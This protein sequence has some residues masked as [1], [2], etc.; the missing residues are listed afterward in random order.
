MVQH[1]TDTLL[2]RNG[3]GALM[4]LST[5]DAACKQAIVDAGG[6][7]VV[8]AAM[9]HHATDAKVRRRGCCALRSLSSG[10]AACEQAVMDG[11]GVAA[12]VAAMGEHPTDAEV[13]LYGCGALINLAIG[14]AAYAQAVVD[15]GGV[16]A[17]VAAMGQHLEA[18]G[19]VAAKTLTKLAA[20]KA[21]I[22]IIATAV[23][24]EVARTETDCSSWDG[25]REVLCQCALVRLQTALEGAAVAALEH[26]ITQAA[27]VQVDAR[28]LEHARG[29][30]REMHADAERQVRLESFGLGSLEPPNEFVCPITLHKMRGAPLPPSPPSLTTLTKTPT[31]PSVP[32]L[33]CATAQTR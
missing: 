2:Q 24:E 27:A 17:L 26:A 8:V 29:R 1:A 32:L 14:D 28:A 13:Q 33:V 16:S 4:N 6:V 10:D 5:G 21:A 23:L 7:A 15:G 25:L 9:R 3:C 22:T 11:G 20:N 31:L 12:V 18:A 30:V 19:A